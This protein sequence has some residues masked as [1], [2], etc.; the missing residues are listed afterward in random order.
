MQPT[1]IKK[2]VAPA[3]RFKTN[4]LVLHLK[5]GMDMKF[6]LPLFLA[7]ALMIASATVALAKEKDKK[8]KGKHAPEVPAA[9]LYP[10]SA[11]ASYGLFRFTTSL[12]NKGKN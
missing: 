8:D 10:A 1:A 2:A 7:F 3:D 11:L 6:L 4:H 12:N 9:L 5:R